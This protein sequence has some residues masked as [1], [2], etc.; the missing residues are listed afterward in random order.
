MPEDLR[1]EVHNIV[2]E[3]VNKIISKKKKCNKAKWLSEETLQIAE[4]RQKRKERHIHL[5]PEF[6]RIA[7]RDKK[8]FLS[9]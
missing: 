2:Q 9:D 8:A 4:K 5:N 3:V 7:R 1:T 6:Q